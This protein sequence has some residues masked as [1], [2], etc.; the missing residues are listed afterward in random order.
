MESDTAPHVNAKRVQAAKSTDE[1]PSGSGSPILRR[2]KKTKESPL[3]VL[4]NGKAISAI[5]GGRGGARGRG[6]RATMKNAVAEVLA[7][8]DALKAAAEE[9]AQAS[10][11]V[12]ENRL[13]MTKLVYQ[14]LYQTRCAHHRF[15]PQ[16][17]CTST[18]T[19]LPP[20]LC[21]RSHN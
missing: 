21:C 5:A 2:Q 9:G 8:A 15:F 4:R 16:V 1:E 10:K 11:P 19:Y 18:S 13:D 20:A 12:A 17:V 3:K 6:M 14:R 7:M